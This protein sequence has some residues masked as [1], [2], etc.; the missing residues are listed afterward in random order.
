MLH[1]QDAPFT[2]RYNFFL[3][4]DN[5]E[6]RV[7]FGKAVMSYSKAKTLGYICAVINAEDITRFIDYLNQYRVEQSK[8]F[9]SDTGL[10]TYEVAFRVGF[11][12]EKY[13]SRVFKKITGLNPS[14]YRKSK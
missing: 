4:K 5:R 2:K 8:I 3:I 13:F 11:R 1:N 10:K 14:E 7:V 9:L 12:D 6:D